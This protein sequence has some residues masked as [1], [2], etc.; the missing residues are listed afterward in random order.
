[1]N[2]E[3]KV[4]DIATSYVDNEN[5]Y[6]VDVTVSKGGRRTIAVY[7]DSDKGKGVK[8]EDCSALSRKLANH[9]EVEDF[10]EGAYVLEVSS[11]GMGNP[12]K[13]LRQYKKNIGREVQVIKKD[14]IELRGVLADFNEENIRIEIHKKKEVTAIEVSFADIKQTKLV[15]TI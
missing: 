4:W 11:A 14:G 1:M 2:L 3:E 7:L 5:H 10:I 9:F 6:V 15:I 13:V 8:I 12:L